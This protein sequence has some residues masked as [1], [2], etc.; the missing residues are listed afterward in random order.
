[1]PKLGVMYFVAERLVQDCL[2]EF[3]MQPAGFR[4]DVFDRCVFKQTPVVD[5]FHVP[6][7]DCGEFVEQG[8]VFAVENQSLL[9]RQCQPKT[10][11]WKME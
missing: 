9:T 1:M 10:L 7:V 8:L 11:A 4:D 6:F 2:S 5:I 3:G